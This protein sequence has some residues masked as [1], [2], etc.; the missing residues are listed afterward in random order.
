MAIS[1]NMQIEGDLLKVTTAGF[2]ESLEE[3]AEY[4]QTVMNTAIA[5]ECS[6]ILC[7]ER[8]LEYRL[9]TMDTYELANIYAS[10]FPKLVKIAI[11][12]DPQGVA[13]AAFFEDV[14]VNRG[15]MVKA[16]KDLTTAQDWINA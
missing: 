5:H 12:C 13:D 15:L 1:F 14:A 9:N 10:L 16:F 7:D 3:V 8:V 6:R 4:G 2:D 11:V